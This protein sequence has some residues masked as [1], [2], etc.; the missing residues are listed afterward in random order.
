MIAISPKPVSTQ[1]A[2]TDQPA[3]ASQ[4][5]KLVATQSLHGEFLEASIPQ[6]LTDASPQRR[7]AF[8]AVA[9]A[10]PAWYQDATPAQRKT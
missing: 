4:S 1:P 9:T 2:S 3:D 5:V 8:K 6:W 7:E 10:L